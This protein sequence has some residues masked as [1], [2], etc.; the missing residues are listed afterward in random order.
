MTTVAELARMLESHGISVRVLG[1]GTTNVRG[2]S[3][4]SRTVRPGDVFVTWSGTDR[5]GHAFVPDAVEAGASACLVERVV[6]GASVP[7][8]VTTRARTAAAWV[9][10]AVYAH[11]SRAMFVAA[12]TGTNGKSTTALLARWVL[13]GTRPSACIGTLGVVGADGQVRP[14]TEVLTTPGPVQLATWLADLDAEG[15][16]AVVLEASSHALDQHRLDA[17]T[18]NAAVFTTVG[19]DHLDY[20][21]TMDAY[22]AAKRRLTELVAPDGTCVV[23]AEEPAWA[24]LPGRVLR[25]SV[26]GDGDLRALDTTAGPEGTGFTLAHRGERIPVELPLI[27]RYN[28]ENALGAAGVGLVA[29]VSLPDVAA[30]LSAAPQ[31]PGRLET[32][33]REPFQVVV[34]FAHT[35]DA[36]ERVLATLRP[37][38]AG[39]L[40]VVFGAGGDRDRGKR[41]RMGAA[42]AAGAD[43]VIVTSDNPRTEDAEAIID[44]VLAGVPEETAVRRQADRRLAIAQ[45]LDLARPGDLVLLAG[46]GHEREQIIGNER[47]P[48]DEPAIVR[49]HLG[50]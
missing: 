39:R 28:V 31:V 22:V 24:D 50:T 25:F 11:P 9:A 49:E 18:V 14:G 29:G 43:I 1:D 45:A 35:A 38:V 27:G 8:L 6:D 30:R 10:D 42:A 4:D 26:E 12:V 23:R 5:D 48:M 2:V 32:V 41:P 47:V 46:K 15:T 16:R 7:Q 3:Q 33:V 36:L 17:L 37:L 44:D 40:V 21:H 13:A 20:H 34:D 19:Q